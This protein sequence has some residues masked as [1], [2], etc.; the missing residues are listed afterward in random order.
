MQK[1]HTIK[2]TKS[3]KSVLQ[4]MIESF[5]TKKGIQDVLRDLNLEYVTGNQ[6]DRQT[7]SNRVHVIHLMSKFI[8]EL[9]IKTK[10]G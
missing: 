9:K 10:V 4:E 7:D 1:T 6:F 3:A 8:S 2:V 5:D